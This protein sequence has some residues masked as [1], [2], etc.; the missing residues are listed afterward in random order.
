MHEHAL[1]PVRAD[2]HHVA[3]PRFIQRRDG[4]RRG[5]PRERRGKGQVEFLADHRAA[6]QQLHRLLRQ[7]LEA[8]RQE[9]AG[10]T[11]RLQIGDGQRLDAP[12]VSVRDQGAGFEQSVQHGRRHERAAAR[13]FPHD[14]DGLVRQR[15]GHGFGELADLGGRERRQPQ[16]CL[17]VEAAQRGDPRGSSSERRGHDQQHV[18]TGCDPAPSATCPIVRAA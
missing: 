8:V 6:A 13:Q 5:L 3:A 15:T 17:R 10:L 16:V 14:I 12:A 9:R 1:K 2:P 11:R 18:A 4:L 7:Q